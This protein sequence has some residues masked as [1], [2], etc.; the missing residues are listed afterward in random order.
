MLYVLH[1]HQMC[2]P[3]YLYGWDGLQYEAKSIYVPTT[4]LGRMVP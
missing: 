3:A 4:K 2:L 1:I